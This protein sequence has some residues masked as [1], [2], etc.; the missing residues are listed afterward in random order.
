MIPKA[1][2]SF[3][4]SLEPHI[5]LLIGWRSGSLAWLIKLFV[6][7]HYVAD[8]FPIIL[9]YS[10]TSML[11]IFLN[12][13]HSCLFA[14]VSSLIVCLSVFCLSLK[15]R[16]ISCDGFPDSCY[17]LCIFMLTHTSATAAVTLLYKYLFTC[18]SYSFVSSLTVRNY[19][20]LIL[21]FLI[22][23]RTLPGI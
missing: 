7:W 18:L 6:I 14:F 11:V 13:H 2:A 16:I 4:T 22:H 8:T 3:L 19:I 15:Q 12:L 9:C 21:V 23:F 17:L 5:Q 1:A 20:L 10:D